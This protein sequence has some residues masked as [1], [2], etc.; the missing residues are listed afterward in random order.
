MTTSPTNAP[1]NAARSEALAALADRQFDLAIVGGG[2][3]GAGIA[4]DASLR[5]L[6]VA[7]VE[8][9]DF[10][11]GTSSKSSKMVHGGLR[12]LENGELGLVFESVNERNFLM[13]RARHLVRPLPFMVASYRGDRRW[14]ST[15]DLGVWIYEALCLFRT[16]TGRL[17]ETIGPRRAAELEPGLK[18][19]G[20]KGCVVY[21]DAQT[22]DAR[23]TLENVLDA[24]ANGAVVL[25]HARA[26]A[27][28]REGD[29][30][31]G[32]TVHDSLGGGSV[33]VR[34]KLVVNATGPWS[35][36]VRA[37]AGSPGMLKPARGSHVVVDAQRL[38]VTHALMM[39]APRDQR[40]VFTIPWG[41]GRT[42]IGT[43]DTFYEGSLDDVHADTDD[44]QYLL[45]TANK[46]FPDSKLVLADVLA[47]WSGLRPLVKPDKDVNA[48]K[49]SREHL[50]ESKPGFMSISGGKL[51]T[52]R[53]MAEELVDQALTEH[54]GGMR[55]HS[56]AK[57][58]LPGGVGLNS[59][60]D[61]EARHAALEGFGRDVAQNL[62]SMYG[63]RAAM[64][65][66]RIA[67]DASAGEKLDA[68]LGLLWAQVD[69][70]VDVELA[71]TLDD[72]LSRRVPLLLR[73]RDQGLSVAEAVAARM[74]TKLGWSEAR[75]ATELA[76]YRA[77]VERSRRFRV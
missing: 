73:G 58:P 72:V 4:R 65:T 15:I 26:G 8:K 40:V 33:D 74:A 75:R 3:T 13:T 48:S 55:P 60:D 59:E 1:G 32:V 18:R 19:D 2:I 23:L 38:P 34:A 35:D 42:V 68:E 39:F 25:N 20:L 43:T 21:A 9:L 29:R 16:P 17:H 12:Y 51:T 41:P 46:Y 70:A 69:E 14:L 56:T 7:L 31:T 11:A 76:G 54:L 77:V 63:S 45:D 67:R 52:Y 22:D 66:E 28:L 53:R 47:T 71:A 44:V 37:L 36:E 27:L 57:R 62:V 5:G 49:V 61:V 30:V 10:A 6:K 50:V 64:V 24:K